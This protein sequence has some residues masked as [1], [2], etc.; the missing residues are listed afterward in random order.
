MDTTL[1][2]VEMR[3]IIRRVQKAGFHVV[4]ISTD[5]HQGNQGLARALGV[6]IENPRFPNPSKSREGDFIYWLYDA[7]HIL[8]NM[9]N[10]LLDDGFKERKWPFDF[11]PKKLYKSF[12]KMSHN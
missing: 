2:E 6:T 7:P 4:A 12:W 3:N 1:R 10:W 11:L 8:K 5:M 9:R